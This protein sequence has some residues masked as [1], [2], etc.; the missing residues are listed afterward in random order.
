MTEDEIIDG[1]TKTLDNANSLYE[2]A[3]ILENN[4]RL[5][6]AYLLFQISIEEI[7]KACALFDILLTEE[8]KNLSALAKFLKA[9]KDHKFK[10]K[11]AI[12]IDTITARLIDDREERLKFIKSIGIQY[13]NI[14]KINDMKNYSLYVSYFREGFQLPNLFITPDKVDQIKFLAHTRLLASKQLFPSLIK[15]LPEL[16]PE[17]L[18]LRDN[19]TD[20]KMAEIAKRLI[21]GET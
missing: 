3:E 7:G 9:Y 6:R 19:M 15:H 4:K 21:D 5:E 13:D 11:R 12:S 10:T 1:I 8:H 16:R 18:K 14:S 17:Y 20:E 2:E